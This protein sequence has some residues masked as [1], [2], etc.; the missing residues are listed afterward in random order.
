MSTNV[1]DK[2]KNWS[3]AQRRKV[4]ARATELIAEEMTLRELRHARKLT[5]VRLAKTLGVT[6]D[7]V[8][9]LEKQSDLL[10][11]TLRKTVEAMGGFHSPA[12]TNHWRTVFLLTS[13]PCPL[14][15]CSLANAAPKSCPPAA[16]ANSTP[17]IASFRRY[18]GSM[19]VPAALHDNSV[20]LGFH[21]Y[22]QVAYPGSL[23]SHLLSACRPAPASATPANL[24]PPG[25]SRFVPPF[26]LSAVKR[27]FYF[28]Q[29]GTSHFGATTG[30]GGSR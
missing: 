10:L 13:M 6:Q 22:R 11:S 24:A 18:A 1:N 17:G 2:I 26:Q 12:F 19:P 27:S 16:G 7:N 3:P 14:R 21:P 30:S 5:Q 28:A 4:E 23:K 15:N 25:S 29:L 9:R 20:A 8:L